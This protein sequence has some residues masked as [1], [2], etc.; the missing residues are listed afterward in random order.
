[1]NLRTAAAPGDAVVADVLA[2][3]FRRPPGQLAAALEQHLLAGALP[4]LFGY[5]I[6]QLGCHHNEEL[7][8]SSR[9][10]HRVRVDLAEGVGEGI[11]LRCAE[12][13]LPLAA[14]TIDVLVLPHVLEFADDPRRV[15]REV[16]R[17]L[18]GEGHIVVLCFNPW[19]WYGLC[20][21]F[22]RWQGRA[23]WSGRFI[24]LS[25]VK[26]WLQLL[27]FDIVQVAR[28]GFRPPSRSELFNRA[29]AFL[30]RLG[31]FCCPALGNLYLVVGK[32]RVEGITPLRVSWRQRRRVLA[33]GMVE[34]STR[35]SGCL[36]ADK[37]TNAHD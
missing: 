18:I 15:L 36:K 17:V 7:L 21:L 27:G 14:N 20:S 23:P 9:I 2:A 29:T 37:G 8:A 28:A 6:V 16:E 33:G 1:M 5:H 3:W 25:R 22:L 35:G 31:A 4:D 10:S 12:E 30:E 24:S 34:P 19:S 26:D 11:Q 32:K 13:A